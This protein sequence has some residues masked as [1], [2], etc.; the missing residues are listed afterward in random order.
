MQMQRTIANTETQTISNKQSLECVQTLLKAGLGC[1]AYLRGLLPAENFGEYRLSSQ[2][3]GRASSSSG[4]FSSDGTTGLNISGF[5]FMT[6]N[7]GFTNEGDRIID[8]LENGI[9]EA[10]DKQ[11]L[12][13]VI[14]GIY[15]DSKDPNNIVEAYTFNFQ[16]H[17]LPGSHTAIPIMTLGD[18]LSKMSLARPDPVSDALKKGKLPTLGEVKRS[19]KV[20]IKSLIT[21]INQMESLPK[22]RYGNFKLFFN[23]DAPDDYQ[24]P[25]FQAADAEANKWF[26]TTHMANE[27]PERTS[28]GQVNAGWHGLDMK[29][30][31][32]SSY[33]PSIS[34]DNNAPFAGITS[35]TA[36][37]LTPVEE[38]RIRVEDAQLQ[39]KDA[40]E[41][42][43]V[44]SADED[45][46][47]EGEMV[48]DEGIVLCRFGGD[49][50]MTPVGIRNEDGG[51]QPFPQVNDTSSRAHVRYGGISE[52]T[53][54]CVGDLNIKKAAHDIEETQQIPATQEIVMGSPIPAPS[55]N[56]APSLPASDIAFSASAISTQE[57]DTQYLQDLLG[58]RNDVSTAPDLEML[59]METQVLEASGPSCNLGTTGPQIPSNNRSKGSKQLIDEGQLSCDCGIS[60]I[61]DASLLC[62]GDCNR[63]FHV[64]CMGYHGAQDKRLPAQFICFD[65]RLRGSHEWDIIAGMIHADIIA[66]YKDLALF[67]RAIKI[68]EVYQPSSASLFRVHTGCDTALVGQ[69]LTRLEEE[70]FIAVESIVSDELGIGVARSHAKKGKKGVK[71]KKQKELQKTKYVFLSKAKRS[72]AYADYFNPLTEVENRLMGLSDTARRKSKAGQT[73]VAS[74]EITDS[75]LHPEVTAQAGSSDDESQT[76]E[77]TQNVL[78]LAVAH[79][80]EKR[81]AAA[82]LVHRGKRVKIS[83]GSG[84]DLCD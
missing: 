74:T 35:H 61:D 3:N 73:L 24:P 63:W 52:S 32:V 15:L 45:E 81:K 50:V 5:K 78:T 70:G 53:P 75:N 76:Q 29:V 56:K 4:S 20:M 33:L 17:K 41:R 48:I 66:R 6:L 51:V 26:F 82:D 31:S 37:R 25:H 9:F 49:V 8:Y 59:D 18:Q 7:R 64:W 83:I 13:K 69:L 34:E 1:V 38:A 22:N 55:P 72:K 57:V 16:Y 23:E 44:W 21:T 19:V 80:A 58:M 39:K 27:V 68:Y 54:I 36:P 2:N 84:V 60:K 42:N 77:A 43:I 10:I 14:F 28:I 67:R 71:S 30:V 40:L 65:C 47:A 79:Q 46:D 12:R 11:Y 62:E